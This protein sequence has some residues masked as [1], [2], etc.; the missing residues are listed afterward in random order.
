MT[1]AIS[2]SG[3]ARPTEGLLRLELGEQ[4][5]A[6]DLVQEGDAWPALG[7][8]ALIRIIPVLGGLQRGAAGQC[9]MTPALAA[10]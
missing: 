8:T 6:G 4:L 5:L 9:A 1:L 7:A 2:S 10:A 3:V